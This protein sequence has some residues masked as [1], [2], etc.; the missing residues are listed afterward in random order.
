MTA[1]DWWLLVT[2]PDAGW[3]AVLLPLV[4]VGL[5]SP[6]CA[7][8]FVAASS[9]TFGAIGDVRPEI[10]RPGAGRAGAAWGLSGER[11]R[12]LL[13]LLLETPSRLS[14]MAPSG[15]IHDRA[16]EDVSLVLRA[17]VGAKAVSR[18]AAVVV[19]DGPPGVPAPPFPP[20]KI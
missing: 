10:P 19:A 6:D 11:L 17:C 18:E 13:R 5:A 16:K 3:E 14:K 9:T 15:S 12:A 4:G 7:C 8:C 1:G 20:A 2:A